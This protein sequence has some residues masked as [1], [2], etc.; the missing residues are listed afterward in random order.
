M[1]LNLYDIYI[2]EDG[3]TVAKQICVCQKCYFG[4]FLKKIVGN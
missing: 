1:V 2:L 4:N 3:F